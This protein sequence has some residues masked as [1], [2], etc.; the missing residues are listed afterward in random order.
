MPNTYAKYFRKRLLCQM[1]TGMKGKTIS[2]ETKYG[3]EHECIVFNLLLQK[4]GFYYYSVVRANGFNVQQWA[5]R[6]RKGLKML[7]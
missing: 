6:E 4:D 2:I 7:L 1:P 3:K 5:K